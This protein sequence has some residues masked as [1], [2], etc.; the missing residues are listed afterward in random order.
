MPVFGA[1][2]A[3][4]VL[5]HLSNNS[6]VDLWNALIAVSNL[7]QIASLIARSFHVVDIVRQ[8]IAARS[9]AHALKV[10]RLRVKI[11]IHGRDKRE[12]GVVAVDICTVRIFAGL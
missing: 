7:S 8:R 2:S 3:V 12:K 10:G 11:G 1:G 5:E 9:G 4:C 6:H